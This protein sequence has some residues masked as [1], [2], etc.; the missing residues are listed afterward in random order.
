[1]A[2]GKR[3]LV[4]GATGLSGR[5]AARELKSAG[6]EVAGLSRSGGG[7]GLDRR[8]RADLMDASATREALSAEGGVSHLF[9]CTWSMQ[10][11][12]AE[13]IRVNKAM[14]ENLFAALPASAP[15]AHVAL[16]TGLKHYLGPFEAYAKAKP[17]S[18]FRESQ[19]RLPYPN[20]YY[21]Q[22]DVVFAEA[23]RRGFRW[24]VHRPHTMIG[25][26][27]GNAMN[28]AVTLAVYASICRETG[29]PFVFPGSTAQYNAI[30]DVT[31]ARILA[32]QLRWAAE[33]PE[34]RDVPLNIVNGDVFRWTWLWARIA[35][36]FGLEH[37]PHPGHPV[38]LVTQM[39]EAGPVWDAMVQRHGLEPWPVDRLAS[40]W[41]SDA[42]L[43]REIECVT[44]MTNSRRLGFREWQEAE[45]SFTDVF[46]DL[47]ARRIIPA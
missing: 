29:R 40:F 38:P 4:I 41:H 14:L 19:P 31:D 6:W 34:V 26:A 8:L 20:F 37:A 47:R 15:L 12:E 7:E 32:K 23:A 9:I 16:V 45:R 33:S 13:N 43:G 3:A 24:T 27:L 22:E 5:Y 2:E 11:S 46:D 10:G 21:D 28:M 42:D 44:D 17:E 30:T 39:K 18:P 1:M 35:A 25:L 36:Y